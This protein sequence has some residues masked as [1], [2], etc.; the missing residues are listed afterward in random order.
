MIPTTI[1]LIHVPL[2]TAPIRREDTDI[3]QHPDETEKHESDTK[4]VTITATRG[5]R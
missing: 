3:T 1:W 4:S 5:E 2:S